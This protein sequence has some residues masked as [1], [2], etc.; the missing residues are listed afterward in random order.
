MPTTRRH[1]GACTRD[2]CNVVRRVIVF[3]LV[4]LLIALQ[5]GKFIL[6]P[7]LRSL[8][9]HVTNY[10]L[11]SVTVFYVLA[12]FALTPVGELRCGRCRCDIRCVAPWF[13]GCFYFVHALLWFVVLSVTFMYLTNATILNDYV[14][15]IGLGATIVGDDAVHLGQLL[16]LLYFRGTFPE[17]LRYGTRAFCQRCNMCVVLFVSFGGLATLYAFYLGVLGLLRLSVTDVYYILVPGGVGILAALVVALACN[18]CLLGE[19]YFYHRVTHQ[20]LYDVIEEEKA[21]YGDTGDIDVDDVDVDA[22][23]IDYDFLSS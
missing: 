17:L 14:A 10:A 8:V 23:D 12:F 20:P 5:V 19:Y 13:A 2:V 4:V 15:S 22:R 21:L 7:D 18:G 11:F 16:L 3:V 1:A 9:S 6:H